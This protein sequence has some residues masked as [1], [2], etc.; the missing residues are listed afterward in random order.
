[1][2]TT[3]YPSK[4]GL[5]SSKVQRFGRLCGSQNGRTFVPATRIESTVV[6]FLG[7]RPTVAVPPRLF[8]QIHSAKIS[9]K[10]TLRASTGG[11]PVV[12]S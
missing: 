4:R 6:M 5:A 8:P 12:G 11:N 2:K 7:V 9:V 1:M 10:H 3:S